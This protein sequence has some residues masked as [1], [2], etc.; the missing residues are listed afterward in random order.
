MPS[1]VSFQLV[2]GIEAIASDKT[3]SQTEGHRGVISPLP[4]NQTKRPASHHIVDRLEFSR[5]G[6][7]EGCTE[8]ISHGKAEKAS[9]IAFP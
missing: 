3:F 7:F 9:S 5:S 1:G 2:D 6:E 8:G 4:G